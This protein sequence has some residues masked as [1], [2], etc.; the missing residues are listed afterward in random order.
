MVE[1]VVER[2]PQAGVGFDELLLEALPEPAVEI[3]EEGPAEVLVETKTLVRG[4][5]SVPARGRRG[6]GRRGGILGGG[7]L[8]GERRGRRR[9]LAVGREPYPEY[10]FIRSGQSNCLKMVRF[11]TVLLRIKVGS[12]RGIADPHQEVLG[13]TTPKLP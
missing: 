10:D 7:A 4:E 3:V 12:A 2:A 13:N 11:R 6:G 1:Q 9:P 8:G 5:G